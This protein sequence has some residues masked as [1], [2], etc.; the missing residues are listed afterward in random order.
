MAVLKKVS[1]LILAVLSVVVH[2]NSVDIY[3]SV[4]LLFR[5]N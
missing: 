1:Y 3:V 5:E 4:V 2:P